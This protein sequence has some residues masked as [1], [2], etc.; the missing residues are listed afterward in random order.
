MINKI[1]VKENNK[2]IKRRKK[3]ILVLTT[4]LLFCSS[5]GA[6][7]REVSKMK[8]KVEETSK[9]I[10]SRRIKKHDIVTA[11]FY[12]PEKR[13]CDSNPLITADN[14]EICLKKLRKKRIKWIAVSRDLLGK[15][16]FGDTVRVSG[17]SDI[18][19]IYEVHDTMNKRYT[20]RI[21][22]LTLEKLEKG[23]WKNIKIEKVS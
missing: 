20:K 19:G 14:S 12:N 6:G 15:Y 17:D 8:N 13:Q 21:D 10:S 1:I 7:S 23:V 11:T 18:A 3:K 2:L 5:F 4:L 22:I 9:N 16:S